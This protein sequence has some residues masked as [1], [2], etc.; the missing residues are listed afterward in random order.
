MVLMTCIFF[1][2]RNIAN[3][4]AN[5]LTIQSVWSKSSPHTDTQPPSSF[6]DRS[7]S[8]IF[9]GRDQLHSFSLQFKDHPTLSSLRLLLFFPHKAFPSL[10]FYIWGLTSL[11]Q[12]YLLSSPQFWYCSWLPQWAF[13]LLLSLSLYNLTK[14]RVASRTFWDVPA[15]WV[16][17]VS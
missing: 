15:D 17:N 2:Y 10:P 11:L 4:Q 3:A 14:T 8:K 9:C 7:V 16:F 12:P 5:T 13:A 1:S 6:P